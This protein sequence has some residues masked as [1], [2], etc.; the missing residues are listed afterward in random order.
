MPAYKKNHPTTLLARE[1]NDML[2]TPHVSRFTA[3]P[4][5]PVPY[6]RSRKGRTSALY[7]CVNGPSQTEN[8]A[9]YAMGP[10]LASPMSTERQNTGAKNQQ[11]SRD[12]CRA[13]LNPLMFVGDHVTEHKGV[14]S[15]GS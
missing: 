8:A 1:M 10:G 12:H 4:R 3:V 5:R 7:A 9:M 6:A 2:R 11:C 14:V 13:I 15:R